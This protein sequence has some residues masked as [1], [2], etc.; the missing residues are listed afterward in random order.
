MWIQRNRFIHFQFPVICHNEYSTYVLTGVKRSHNH[1]RVSRSKLKNK[2]IQNR[3][4]GKE[5]SCIFFLLLLFCMLSFALV[6]YE[7]KSYSKT[8]VCFVWMFKVDLQLDV[9]NLCPPREQTHVSYSKSRRQILLC[10]TYS[11][12]LNFYI[13]YLIFVADCT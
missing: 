2:I 11:L 5:V 9:T 1:K 6:I 8:Y 7:K 3:Q 13:L 12:D 10:S 4:I